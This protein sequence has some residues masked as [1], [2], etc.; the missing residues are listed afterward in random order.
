MLGACGELADNLFVGA[1]LSVWPQGSTVVELATVVAVDRFSEAMAA[2]LPITTKGLAYVL[3]GGAIVPIDSETPTLSG[4]VIPRRNVLLFA[5]TMMA[6]YNFIKKAFPTSWNQAFEASWLS[7]EPSVVFGECI[8][9]VRISNQMSLTL[10]TSGDFLIYPNTTVPDVVAWLATFVRSVLGS[11]PPGYAADA[12]ASPI[13][14]LS[15]VSL[16]QD[17]VLFQGGSVRCLVTHTISSAVALR[18]LRPFCYSC[19]FSPPDPHVKCRA[20]G[21][22]MP[23][24]V[25]LQR[26]SPRSQAGSRTVGLV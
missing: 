16:Y 14:P 19:R 20:L 1:M 7:P 6:G 9:T 23:S 12:N 4:E 24:Q 18:P 25:G 10:N 5:N 22:S 8:E 21:R 3:A 15:A 17:A 26:A 13:V 11:A 2:F